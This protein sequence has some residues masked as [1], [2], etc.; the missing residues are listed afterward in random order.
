MPAF[1]MGTYPYTIG[2]ILAIVVLLLAILGLI[3]VIPLTAPVV[4]GMFAALAVARLT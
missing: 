3:G 4:F 1:T 2:A